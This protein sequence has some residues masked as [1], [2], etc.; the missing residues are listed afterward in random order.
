MHQN[1]S[2][3]FRRNA[4]LYGL[5]SCY[6][7][8]SAVS[9]AEALA[10]AEA[11]SQRRIVHPSIIVT[12]HTRILP[13]SEYDVK[14]V[15]ARQFESTVVLPGMASNRSID[16]ARPFEQYRGPEKCDEPAAPVTL[17]HNKKRTDPFSNKSIRSSRAILWGQMSIRQVG[18][19][20]RDGAVFVSGL[21]GA[22][23]GRCWWRSNRA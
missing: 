16:A 11:S 6:S 23:P 4:C 7:S 13:L 9:S 19:G 3:S 12:D 14:E 22:G 10:K 20:I 21:T 8:E 2:G 1:Q 15:I 17:S 18:L 5:P